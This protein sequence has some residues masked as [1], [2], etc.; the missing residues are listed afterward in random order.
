MDERAA[1][2]TDEWKFMGDIVGTMNAVVAGLGPLGMVTF[3]TPGA[4]SPGQEQ[5]GL[6]GKP[7]TGSGRVRT[8]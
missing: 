8:P 1:Y 5:I 7:I 3:V 2:H 4:D 6:R